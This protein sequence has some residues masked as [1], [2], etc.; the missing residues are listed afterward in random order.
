MLHRRTRE[1]FI[2]R[3]EAKRLTQGLLDHVASGLWKLLPVTDSL[4]RRTSDLIAAAPPNLFLRSADA[5]HLTTAREAGE[6][7]IW[8]NDRHMLAAAPHFGLKGRSV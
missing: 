5:V 1:Q 2:T 6:L 4:V 3:L 7:E 8:T